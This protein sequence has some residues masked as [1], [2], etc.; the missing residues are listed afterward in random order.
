MG[1]NNRVG[2]KIRINEKKQAENRKK[3]KK[4]KK[5]EIRGLKRTIA[6]A[7]LLLLCVPPVLAGCKASGK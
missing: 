4:R 3:E 7:L 5:G 1:G 2:S 6:V